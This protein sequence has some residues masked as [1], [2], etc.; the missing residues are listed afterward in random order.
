VASLMSARRTGSSCDRASAGVN[1]RANPSGART[2]ER[3][4]APG[5]R[6]AAGGAAVVDR[7]VADA[8]PTEDVA[9]TA[10]ADTAEAEVARLRAEL[11]RLRRPGGDRD[12]RPPPSASRP[13]F[14]APP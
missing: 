8:L 1:N 10:R 7:V 2:G 12:G 6:R 4:G 14:A 3:T 13:L 5:E 11:A 9:A